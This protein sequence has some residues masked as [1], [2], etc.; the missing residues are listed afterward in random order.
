MVDEVRA[1][2]AQHVRRQGAC[3]NR[4]ARHSGVP[5]ARTPC[6]VCGATRGDEERVGS[7]L[8]LSAGRTSFRYRS[9][10]CT[11]LAEWHQPLLRAFAGAHRHAR[12]QIG[13]VELQR[14]SS[15]TPSRLR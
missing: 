10:Q 9:I 14:H 7:R 13:G 2:H 5:D 3:P 15:E 11:L 1:T 6:R 8:P 4:L 12:L